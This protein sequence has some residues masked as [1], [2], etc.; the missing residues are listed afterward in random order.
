VTDSA[1][2]S[3]RIVVRGR[4]SERFDSAFA[5]MTLESDAT[6]TSLVG[7]VV[8]QSHLYGLI[9]HVRSFGLELISVEP[10]GG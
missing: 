5:G 8:D 2:T 1:Q 6:T 4:L 10:L 9:E 7:S 3:Y